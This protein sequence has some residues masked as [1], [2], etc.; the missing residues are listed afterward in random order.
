VI[1]PFSTLGLL[2]FLVAVSVLV[3]WKVGQGFGGTG[4]LRETI[5]IVAWYQFINLCLQ[6]VLILSEVVLPPLAVLVI[7]VGS[8]AQMWILVN[9]V[10][11]LHGFRSI[12]KT[13]AGILGII[14]LISFGLA[15]VLAPYL[16]LPA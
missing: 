1:S 8:V 5:S 6:V 15:L 13:F 11:E 7:A 14:M 4:G 3:V 10:A 2:A 12:G 9:F 16:N